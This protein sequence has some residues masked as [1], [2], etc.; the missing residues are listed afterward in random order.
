MHNTFNNNR[1]FTFRLD[2]VYDVPE[3]G[4]GD[5]YMAIYETIDR[6]RLESRDLKGKSHSMEALETPEPSMKSFDVNNTENEISSSNDSTSNRRRHRLKFPND[7]LSM[8]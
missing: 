6:K 2:H 5:D 7:Y 1:N 8:K 3:C 4:N